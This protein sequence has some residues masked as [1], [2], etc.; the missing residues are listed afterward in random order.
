MYV[1]GI[2]VLSNTPLYVPTFTIVQVVE[3]SYKEGVMDWAGIDP[4]ACEPVSLL[5]NWR[6]GINKIKQ[7]LPGYRVK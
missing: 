5:K 1:N 6:A 7:M 2:Y 3:I 4:Y